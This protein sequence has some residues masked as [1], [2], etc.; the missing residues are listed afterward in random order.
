MNK[1]HKAYLKLNLMSLFFVV[2]SFISIT[3]AWFA[4]SGLARVKT[5]V[6]VKAWYI[7]F[8]QGN[9]SVS[10][11][12]VISLSEIY[13]GMETISEIID[14]Q[15]LGDSD[16]EIKYEII[17]ARIFDEEIDVSNLEEGLINDKLSQQYPFHINIGITDY[18]IAAK[19][20]SGAFE[21][22][23]SWPLD[24]DNDKLDSIW[25]N[26]A[27]QF[28]QE[29]ENKKLADP[30]YVVRSALKIVISVTVEQYIESN[31]SPDPNYELGDTVLYDVVNNQ[32]C[33]QISDTCLKTYVIDANNKIGDPNVS[34]L[35]SLYRTYESS[36]YSNYN[37]TLNNITSSWN[38]ST[39][40]LVVDDL[41]NIISNDVIDSK[42][43]RPNLS[44]VIIGNLNYPDRITTMI[45]NAVSYDG[46]FTFN[47]ER[48]SDLSSN[49]CY[50]LNSEYDINKAFAFEKI[51]DTTSKIYGNNKTNNCSVIPVIIVAKSNL[52]N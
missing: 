2:V 16:A 40:P 22:S 10:N 4:Y 28:Q 38:V 5:E 37:T 43:V 44:D 52:G 34:L 7:D 17:S 18:H 49:K 26:A 29:E 47:N 39:R 31:E 46:Y 51:D 3:L 23:V 36:S 45:N 42:L 32:V 19:T 9:T 24:A 6:N 25:G 48:F 50:W 33:D 21:V 8:K 27:Y 14:I 35:P 12:I 20:G 11:D 1:K 13:P 41:L 30:D 15:N